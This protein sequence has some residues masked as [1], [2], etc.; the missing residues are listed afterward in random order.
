[1]NVCPTCKRRM[2]SP[3]RTEDKRLTE[4]RFKAKRSL[5]ILEAALSNPWYFDL[6]E[7]IQE[8]Q[9][10]LVRALSDYRLL[11]TIYRRNGKGT[12][13]YEQREEMAA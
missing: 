1:M 5:A 10:R 9:V 12:P 8:E 4:D 11:W 2:P 13:Y 6:T 7:A 3:K